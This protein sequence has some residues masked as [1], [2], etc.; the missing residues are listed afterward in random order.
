VPEVLEAFRKDLA[1]RTSR[2]GGMLAIRTQQMQLRAVALFTRFLAASGRVLVDPARDLALP[3]A[4][5]TLP[6]V[7]TRREIARLLAAPSS[8]SLRGRR[9]RA[10]LGCLYET[11]LRI[12]EAIRLAVADIDWGA[13]TLAVRG[14]KGGQDRVVPIGPVLAALLLRYLDEVRSRILERA[15]RKGPLADPGTL[16]LS[17]RGRAFEASTVQHLVG[18]HARAA[19]L[20]KHVTPHTLRHTCATHLLESGADLRIVQELLGHRRLVSTERYT[21]TTLAFLKKV[22]RNSHPREREAR[23]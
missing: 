21:R 9:D 2:R 23:S 20:K 8:R 18:V 7:L 6:E 17:G 22:H 10:L 11:G 15:A 5:K 4:P 14:G 1:E 19:R 13:R 12:S 3:R 16:F